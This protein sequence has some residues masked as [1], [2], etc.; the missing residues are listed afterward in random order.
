M[1]NTSLVG[2]APHHPAQFRRRFRSHRRRLRCRQNRSRQCALDGRYALWADAA[3]R[4]DVHFELR[5]H[6]THPR[7]LIF[8]IIVPPLGGPLTFS[9]SCSLAH[10][11][12]TQV[13]FGILY[14][15][16]CGCFLSLSP[17]VAAQL[18]GSGRLAGLSGLMLLFNLPGATAPVLSPRTHN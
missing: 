10:V 12:L 13:A 8:S 17:A 3:P 1:S 9:R 11:H 5:R 7:L 2:C 15:L 4:L 16:V 18:Y 14:G 6:R